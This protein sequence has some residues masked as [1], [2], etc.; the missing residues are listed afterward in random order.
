MGHKSD[1]QARVNYIKKWFQM[2]H[3]AMILHIFSSLTISFGSWQK[4]TLHSNLAKFELL[5]MK[6]TNTGYFT[7]IEEKVGLWGT[8]RKFS[9]ILP[10]S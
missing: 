3:P 8:E 6:K 10:V 9:I 1:D 5:M 7:A 2:T 4:K